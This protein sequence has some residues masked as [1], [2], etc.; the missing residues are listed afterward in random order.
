MVQ[1]VAG[2]IGILL[3][4]PLVLY[5][6]Q[7]LW[8]AEKKREF[9]IDGAGNK[10]APQQ[11]IYFSEQEDEDEKKGKPALGAR[12]TALCMAALMAVS[13]L[14]AQIAS[15]AETSFGEDR[16]R[17]GFYHGPLCYGD[18]YRICAAEN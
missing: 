1:S 8:R 15:A 18:R 17:A 10:T 4:V 5:S 13:M 14:P 2:S 9:N 11:H 12:L 7:G 16:F 6:A 3:T